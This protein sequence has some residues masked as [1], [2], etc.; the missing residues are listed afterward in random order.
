VST[1]QSQDTDD[2]PARSNERPTVKQIFLREAIGMRPA[3]ETIRGLRQSIHIYT[4]S[5]FNLQ[6]EVAASAPIT[7]FPNKAVRV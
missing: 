7:Y 4:V 2:E 3:G 6:L 1:P 5:H